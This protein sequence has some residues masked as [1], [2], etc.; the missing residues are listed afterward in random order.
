MSDQAEEWADSVVNEIGNMLAND[1][2]EVVEKTEEIENIMDSRWVYRI[3][4][5]KL[6]LVEKFKSRI[7][8]TNLKVRF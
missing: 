8:V 4:L 2:F 7:D 1:V 5:D 3:K 6:G